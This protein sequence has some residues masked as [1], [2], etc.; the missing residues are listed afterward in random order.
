[1]CVGFFVL[2]LLAYGESQNLAM[3]ELGT[4]VIYRCGTVTHYFLAPYLLGG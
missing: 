3:Y 2:V 4:Y 1:M